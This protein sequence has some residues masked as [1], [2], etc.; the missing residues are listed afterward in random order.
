MFRTPATPAE[1]VPKVDPKTIVDAS[2]LRYND[3]LIIRLDTATGR[4]EHIKAVDEKGNV[5]LPFVGSIKL[6]GMTITQAQEAVRNLYVPRYYS[7]LTVT[8]VL[9]TQ[10]FVYL[11]GALGVPGGSMPYRDDM[12]VY[13]AVQ[14][15]GGFSEFGKKREVELTR[16]GKKII[17]DCVEIERHPELDVPVLPGDI[18]F[19]PKSNF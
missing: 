5:E 18:I 16:G 13:R 1:S 11:S 12:T 10:R 15:S 6:E 9:Q 8:I 19:V 2:K 3:N 17:V 14:A 7:Y 4:E